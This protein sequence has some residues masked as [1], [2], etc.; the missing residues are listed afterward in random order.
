MHHEQEEEGENRYSER[1]GTCACVILFVEVPSGVVASIK[2]T[3]VEVDTTKLQTEESKGSE[4]RSTATTQPFFD[5][6]E[7][8]AWKTGPSELKP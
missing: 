3:P 7:E 6:M 8:C 1:K 2:Y 5:G 4:S